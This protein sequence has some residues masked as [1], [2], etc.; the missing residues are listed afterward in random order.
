MANETQSLE[1][2]KEYDADYILVFAT[3]DTYGN[4]VNMGDEG[5]WMWMARISGQANERFIEDGY[6]DEQDSFGKIKRCN[7]RA[8]FFIVGELIQSTRRE[9]MIIN[10]LLLNSFIF[11]RERRL[12]RKSSRSSS[13]NSS[14]PSKIKR[15]LRGFFGLK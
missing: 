11:T 6:I 14:N 8:F 12:F 1:M 2:L 13:N 4:W 3:F 5:K 9:L 10:K 7:L 15:I